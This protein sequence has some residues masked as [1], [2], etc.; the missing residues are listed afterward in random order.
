MTDI[1]NYTKECEDPRK[2]SDFY[3]IDIKRHSLCQRSS[4]KIVEIHSELFFDF[5]KLSTWY[6][7]EHP[8]NVFYWKMHTARLW[9][10]FLFRDTF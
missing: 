8:K 6:R 3:N 5:T 2:F 10:Q 4:G 1:G 7:K 9:L